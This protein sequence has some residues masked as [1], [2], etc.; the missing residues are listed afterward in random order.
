M[1]KIKGMPNSKD[2]FLKYFPNVL[3]GKSKQNK[4]TQSKFSR[5]R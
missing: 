4:E 2:Y 3:E 1:N 5:I